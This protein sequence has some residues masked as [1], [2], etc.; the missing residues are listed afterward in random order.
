MKKIW[1]FLDENT[2]TVI[3]MLSFFIVLL[4]TIGYMVLAADGI[5]VSDILVENF[6]KFFGYELIALSG[7]KIAKH[8]RG[9]ADDTEPLDTD[10][11]LE[12]SD[13]DEQ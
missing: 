12:M 4:F 8:I 5:I 10:A 2:S 11:A 6:Y 7:I 3:V 9:G 13:I 1:K